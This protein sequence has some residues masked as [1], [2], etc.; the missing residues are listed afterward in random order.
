[1]NIVILNK[2]GY[3][4]DIWNRYLCENIDINI[5]VNYLF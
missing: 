2:Y 4:V 5:F 3:D 1:M